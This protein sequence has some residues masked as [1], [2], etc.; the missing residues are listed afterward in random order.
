MLGF[1]PGGVSSARADIDL[2]S[3]PPPQ[4]EAATARVFLGESVEIPLRGISRG[5]RPL[6]FLIRRA[7]AKGRLTGPMPTSRNTAV[8]TY[9]PNAKAMPGVDRFRYAVRAPGT[10]VSTPAEVIIEVAERP[11]VFE[12][13]A[14][15][16]FPAVALGESVRQSFELRN[17]GGGRIV[18]RMLV[19]PP[20]KVAAGDGRYALGPGQSA[21]F[22]LTFSPAEP[23]RY[24][25]SVRF[26][27]SEGAGIGL[28]GRGYQPI[29]I[30]PRA[31]RL[32]G[33]GRAETRAAEFV[34]RN[35]SD[36]ERE[37]R[38]VAPASVI[39]EDVV[40]VPAGAEVKVALHTRAG[41]LASLNDE[42]TFASGDLAFRIP[43]HVAAAPARLVASR[44]E[45]DFG[46]LPAG[47]FGRQKLALRNI[48]GS[49]ATVRATL[50]AGVL[51]QPDPSYEPIAPGQEKPFELSFARPDAGKLDE[52]LTF[53]AGSSVLRLPLK[54]VV[55]PDPRSGNGG[56]AESAPTALPGATPPV[57]LNGLPPVEQIG[58]TRQ[59]YSE[60]DIT[61][62]HVSP[63]ARRYGVVVQR[64]TF[65]GD[66]T[67]LLRFEP[68][69][70]VKPRIVRNEVHASLVGLR[71]GE[72]VT[73]LIVSYDFEGTPSAASAPFVVASK[74]KPPTRIPWTG[75]GIAALVV[76]AALIVRERRRR[77]AALD[78]EIDRLGG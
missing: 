18:G 19:P 64:I 54:A 1:G 7:P 3:V 60:V 73:I 36:V 6:D 57:K 53:E 2:P 38:I 25:D 56:G 40:R 76:F 43:L 31:I 22:A 45:I 69:L 28:D 55:T 46:T 65:R 34:L 11:P 35:V 21:N 17:A 23:R 4:P 72:R 32:E 47:R 8:V 26:S 39:I 44:E 16:E 10:G 48:G 9:T 12:A 67:A 58:I 5:G 13:P 59:T 24:A 70:N 51:L 71:P 30:A 66:G 61:W 33:D 29:E 20:W 42:I 49:P 68:L 74:V 15:L 14:R 63:D 41:F 37:V 52:V 77:R 75:I 27:H 62:R 50:P 78:A